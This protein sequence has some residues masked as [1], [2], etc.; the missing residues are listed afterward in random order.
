MTLPV[1]YQE[2]EW[3]DGV[4]RSVLWHT[5][6]GLLLLVGALGGFGY[7]AATAP[8]S[9]GLISQGSFVA[10]GKNQIVQ[11]LEGGIIA[12][13]LVAEGDEVV[14]GQPLMRLDRTAAF[15]R[16][17]E[18]F[19]RRAR[20]EGITG[21]LA[22]M[23]EG[24][25]TMYLPAFLIE[26]A[27]RPEVDEI[28]TSQRHAFE[29][30]Q[31]KLEIDITVLENNAAALAFRLAGFT[32]QAQSSS[33]LIAIITE[34]IENKSKLLEAGL[35]RADAVN[36][37]RRG[38]AE[39]TGQ[40][41][42]LDSQISETRLM[43]ERSV[44][45]VEQ[46]RSAYLNEALEELQVMQAELDS[47][48]EQ[49]NSAQSVSER[50]EIVA[51]VDGVVV[52]LKYNTPGGVIEPGK[53]IAEILPKGAPLIVETMVQRA[54]IDSMQV[55]QKAM[56]RLVSLNQRTTPV[57]EGE[58][59]YISADAIRDTSTGQASRDV[60]VARIALSADEIARVPGDFQPL[61][62]MPA[63]IIIA[64]S[65]RTFLQYVVKPIV[66]SMARAFRE[67]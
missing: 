38:L 8:L 13:I 51:P 48:R 44:D 55:G 53:P 18:L 56:I 67:Q 6:F 57:L 64:T 65:E 24:R 7:W 61:P 34:E 41:A 12:E 19:L 33:D 2:L 1:V 40:L 4:P 32:E 36:A 22:A 31:H 50:A 16:E 26:N 63:E 21:R 46:A 52:Q 54:D 17:E 59:F 20:L 5:L 62:G 15:A 35:T 10:T 27:H 60:Y 30:A 47:V 25:S 37:L 49:H 29:V 42:R 23:A 9:A 45:Q 28:I 39:A 3:Y 14:A 11:H 58:V 43:L 66:D